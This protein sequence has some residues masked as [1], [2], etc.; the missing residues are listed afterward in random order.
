MQGCKDC[1]C[2][3]CCGGWPIVANKQDARREPLILDCPRNGQTEGAT[4]P[5]ARSTR[6]G[7]K[8]AGGST[9]KAAKDG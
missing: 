3:L 1:R 2:G 7:Q 6:R 8:F 4:L 9:A 5:I